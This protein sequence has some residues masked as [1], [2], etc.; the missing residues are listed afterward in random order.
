D[1]TQLSDD[2]RRAVA[3]QVAFYKEHRMLL[4]Y[5]DF[6]RL[7]RP[8]AENACAWMVV[9]PDKKEAMLGYYRVLVH[10]NSAF[11]LLR[12]AGLDDATLYEVSAV[13]QPVFSDEGGKAVYLAHT[14]QDCFCA[15]GDLL[16]HAGFRPK[17][18]DTSPYALARGDLRYLPD[19]GARLYHIVAKAD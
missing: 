4:Q 3:E 9:S 16:N 14:E 5:G 15:Y 11:E 1:L 12:T 8:D 17:Q 19:F 18:A 6:Y 2:H 7:N 13:P 10:P